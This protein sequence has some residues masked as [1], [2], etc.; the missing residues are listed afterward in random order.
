[1]VAVCY[2]FSMKSPEENKQPSEFHEVGFE[3][4]QSLVALRSKTDNDKDLHDLQNEAEAYAKGD[5]RRAFLSHE[6]ETAT[7]F[8][9]IKLHEDDLPEGAPEVEGLGE[10]AHVARIAVLEEYRGKGIGPQLLAEGEA[11]AQ[12]A[13]KEGMWLDYLAKNEAAE[14][15]YK[16]AGY[17][18]VAEFMDTKKNK[19]RRIVKK[20]FK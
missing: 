13:G 18:V 7:G 15:L 3:N 17:E 10:F 9:E 12:H 1:M 14:K 16:R 19:M 8:V 4:M 6:G 5:G 20:R 11:W 2:T